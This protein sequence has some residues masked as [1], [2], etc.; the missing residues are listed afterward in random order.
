M[1]EHGVPKEQFRM[2][3]RRDGAGGKVGRKAE[4]MCMRGLLEVGLSAQSLEDR[5]AS[6]KQRL[7]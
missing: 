5:L 7:N 2:G 3:G 1:F 4:G 6:Q